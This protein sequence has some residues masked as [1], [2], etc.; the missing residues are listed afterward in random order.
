M[1]TPAL[2]LLS[3]A[4][5]DAP[6]LPGVATVSKDDAWDD[7]GYALGVAAA[8][9]GA[10]WCDRPYFTGHPSIGWL[11]AK[12]DRVTAA[13]GYAQLG[14]EQ[15]LVPEGWT[16]G[17]AGWRLLDAAVRL[18]VTHP[19]RLLAMPP[20]PGTDDWP[21][22]VTPDGPHAVH[23]YGLLPLM[24]AT[25]RWYLRN[26]TGDLFVTEC[27]PGAGNSFDLDRWADEHFR[28]FLDWC[29]TEPRVR[30][31]AYFAW[32]WRR[33]PPM[34]S[35]VD[36]AGTRI[37]TVLRTWRAPEVPV[38]VL[39]GID[40][41]SNNG[42]VDLGLV[43]ADGYAFVAIKASGDEGGGD[44]V[45]FDP[46]FFERWHAANA[47]EL[48]RI[49]FHYGRPSVASPAQ[50]VTTLQRALQAV[51]GLKTGDLIAVDLE[52]PK[53]PDG[54][55]LHQW[56]AEWLALAEQVFGVTPGKY[57]AKYYTSTHDL[58]HPDLERFWTW[59]AAWQA[60]MPA[61]TVGWRPITLWQNSSTAR[62]PGVAG[63]CDTDVFAGTVDQL[64]A[65]GL[66]ESAGPSGPDPAGPDASDFDVAASR[67]RLWTEAD[68]LEANGYPW[69]GAGIKALVAQSKGDK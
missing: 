17:P 19:D 15:N 6:D 35:S 4:D 37:E 12:I 58:E 60:T 63:D 11:V 10:L 59:W 69:F 51:G 62:V 29:A 56:T 40:I 36:A 27:N 45:Y 47:Q 39:K 16:G 13:G 5:A 22:W 61:A 30:M 20:S 57:S 9:R 53:V 64:R 14:N 23:A 46:P 44:N 28:P 33:A 41:S 2:V 26:T 38:A 66:P 55:S 42:A 34:P 48:V 68:A 49:A 7:G 43:K 65:L 67:D 25:V 3:D 32:R 8:A 31:V 24:Q 21:A 1:L 54:V 18:S 52:D 50:S